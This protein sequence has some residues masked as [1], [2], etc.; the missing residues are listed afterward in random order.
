MRTKLSYAT[1]SWQT[2]AQTIHGLHQAWGLLL[3]FVR[4]SD[5]KTDSPVATLKMLDKIRGANQLSVAPTFYSGQIS[6]SSTKSAQIGTQLGLHEDQRRPVCHPF[7]G[8]L[9]AQG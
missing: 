3:S 4:G 1:D 7:H 2:L 9:L 6:Y 5:V 8:V